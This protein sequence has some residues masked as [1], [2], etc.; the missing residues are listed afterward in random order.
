MMSI[1][2]RV[3]IMFISRQDDSS[4]L[5]PSLYVDLDRPDLDLD[6]ARGVS[7]GHV[8]LE[9]QKE[10]KEFVKYKHKTKN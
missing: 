7:T 3:E 4:Y 10:E 2:S 5:L 6:L 9:F 1:I 8:S